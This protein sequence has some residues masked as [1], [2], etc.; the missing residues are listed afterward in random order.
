MTFGR[1]FHDPLDVCLRTL[2]GNADTSRSIL[3][4]SNTDLQRTLTASFFSQQERQTLGYFCKR[5]CRG[6][7]YT[8]WF[9]RIRH[10]VH[11]NGHNYSIYVALNVYSGSTDTYDTLEWPSPAYTVD[12]KM[13]PD[14]TCCSGIA[15]EIMLTV[16]VMVYLKT[17]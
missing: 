4:A 2:V 15:Y 16:R 10:K 14:A 5:L 7:S 9:P 13:K 8:S 12:R 3:S 17:D 6:Y 1:I 11:D